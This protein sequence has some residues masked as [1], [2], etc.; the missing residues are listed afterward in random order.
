MQRLTSDYNFR[1]QKDVEAWLRKDKKWRCLRYMIVDV[2]LNQDQIDKM[3]DILC[4][5]NTIWNRYIAFNMYIYRH[6]LAK[7]TKYPYSFTRRYL[8]AVVNWSKKKTEDPLHYDW[9][10]IPLDQTMLNMYRMILPFAEKHYHALSE[11][12]RIGD[13][14]LPQK[15]NS[16]ASRIKD[17]YISSKHISLHPPV[18]DKTFIWTKPFGT[19]RLRDI[20]TTELPDNDDVVAAML[21]YAGQDMYRLTIKYKSKK[22]SEDEVIEPLVIYGVTPL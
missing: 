19:I 5:C 18:K 20:K 2:G 15:R 1:R 17:V 7:R 10:D 6:F 9:S 16:F 4:A 12:I 14:S 11:D 13:I 22:I 21:S 3:Q 8:R